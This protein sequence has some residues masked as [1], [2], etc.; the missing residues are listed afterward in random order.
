MIV[1]GLVV[2]G[3]SVV[4]GQRLLAV[5]DPPRGDLFP[6]GVGIAPDV[7][8]KP[9]RGFVA[10]L[11]ARFTGCDDALDVTIAIAGTA[12]YF[13]DNKTTLAKRIGFT[14]ALPSKGLNDITVHYGDGYFDATTPLAA[15]PRQHLA[16]GTLRTEAPSER[17]VV[18]R[19]RGSIAR[20]PSHLA[21]LVIQFKAAWL[22]DRGLGSCY[23]KLPPLVGGSTIIAAQDGLGR[24]AQD[25][26][27]F[28][29]RFPNAAAWMSDENETVFVPYVRSL[30]ILNGVS[31]VD[32]GRHEVL[33]YQP[34]TNTISSNFPS[35]ACSHAPPT[36]GPLGERSRVPLPDWSASSTVADSSQWQRRA[37]VVSGTS[38]CCS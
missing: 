10:G 5:E 25:R 13:E 38:F 9:G 24:A 35:L 6:G 21:S 4:V 36:G 37:P 1:I 12:D 34:E 26:D 8:A 23:V 18:T 22:V 16:S 15:V 17:L 19:V 30:A 14:V 27:T 7:R 32:A 20:W 11:G 29:T 2:M 28:A 3:L 33:R 31:V